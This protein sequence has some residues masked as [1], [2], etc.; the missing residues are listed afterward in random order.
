MKVVDKLV[1]IQN[2]IDASCERVGRDKSEVTIIAVTKYVSN[3]R[4]FEAVEAGIVHLGEN[5]EDGLLMKQEVLGDKPIWHFIGTLQTKKVKKIINKIDYLHSLD[6]LSLAEEI[7]KRADHPI[8]C[9]IQVNTSEEDSKHGIAKENVIGFIQEL[10]KYDTIE[11]VGLMTM[12]AFTEDKDEIRRCF[13]ELKSLQTEIIKLELLKTP[14]KHLSM[15]MSND[16]EIAVEEG[17]T[18]IRIGT[19]L[20]GE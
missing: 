13:R 17:A 2:K 12:A 16:F 8:K 15:G 20:V 19:S 11:I 6:R 14:F 5:Y 10:Q 18:M 4:A 1:D 3:E 9:L 7:Q